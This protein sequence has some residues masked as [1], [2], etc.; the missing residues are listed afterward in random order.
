MNITSK[1]G[2]ALLKTES[3]EQKEYHVVF[4]YDN[5]QE[6]CR[7]LPK[8]RMSELSLILSSAYEDDS[9]VKVEIFEYTKLT[10]TN[11]R[12]IE[13]VDIRRNK[14]KPKRNRTS[15]LRTKKR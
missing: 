4:V 10:A 15:R 8:M 14:F 3:I 7:T 6:V 12:P 11:V 1:N 9:I 13:C 5:A 2:S